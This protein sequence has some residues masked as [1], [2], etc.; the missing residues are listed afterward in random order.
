MSLW[1]ACSCEWERRDS[2]KEEIIFQ[3]TRG[4]NG[5]R[6]E[7]EDKRVT[8][9]F[10]LTFDIFQNEQLEIEGNGCPAHSV[11]SYDALQDRPSNAAGRICANDN[12]FVIVQW[13]Y[14]Y[15]LL[16]AILLN[17]SGAFGSS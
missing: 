3:K 5:R 8:G 10:Q 16:L 6:V 2:R 14:Y 9:C 4:R 13:T 12:M 11:I 15:V 1:I 7:G 17:L